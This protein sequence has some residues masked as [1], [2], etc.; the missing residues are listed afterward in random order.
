MEEAK[1]WVRQGLD[2][3]RAGPEKQQVGELEALQ[4]EIHKALEKS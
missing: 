2:F 4:R 1:D 3:E